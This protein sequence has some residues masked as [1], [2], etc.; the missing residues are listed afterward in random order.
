MPVMS[1]HC[2]PISF[3]ASLTVR[4]G[5]AVADLGNEAVLL[6]SESGEYFALNEVASRILELASGETAL[7]HIVTGLMTEFQVERSRL[8]A[9]VLSFVEE[10]E[11]RGLITLS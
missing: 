10:L 7:A 9:D 6:N 5:V 8:E 2:M 1:S 3:E 11:R 4:P